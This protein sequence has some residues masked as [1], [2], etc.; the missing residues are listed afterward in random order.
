MKKKMY[1]TMVS[2]S[3]ADAVRTFFQKNVADGFEELEAQHFSKSERPPHRVDNWFGHG[4]LPSNHR[5]FVAI[6]EANQAVEFKHQLQQC[7]LSGEVCDA[8]T[9]AWEV[10]QF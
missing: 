7:T 2:E 1:V 5:M 3:N 4:L 6:M 9:L 10:E 8:R